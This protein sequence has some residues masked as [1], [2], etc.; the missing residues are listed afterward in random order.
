[1]DAG[2][3][4]GAEQ[5]AGAVGC[6]E[7][8]CHPIQVARRLVQ[9]KTVLMAGDYARLFAAQKSLELC[10]PR[11]LISPKQREKWEASQASGKAAACTNDTVGCVALD[12]EGNLAAG[13]STGGTGD[14]PPGRVGDSPLPGCGY[15]AENGVGGISFTGE[16]EGIMRVAASRGVHELLRSG[17]D[18][19]EAAQRVVR[20]IQEQTGATSGCIVLDGSG[21]IGWNHSDPNMAVAYR[22]REMT[23]GRAFVKKREER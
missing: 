18:P 5:Q 23:E 17:T 21:R 7:G 19:E 3:M 20:M 16:G 4:E 22:T 10:D 2:I 13:A 6:V 11:E 15:L 14:H 8:V 9:E 1:M 12:C